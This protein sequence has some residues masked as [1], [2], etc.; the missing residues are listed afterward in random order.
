[1]LFALLLVPAAARANESATYKTTIAA[2]PD[3]PVV[4]EKCD[5]RKFGYRVAIDGLTY[6]NVSSLQATAVRFSFTNLSAFDDRSAARLYDDLGAISKGAT[7]DRLHRWNTLSDMP[8][9]D[10]DHVEC[11][12]ER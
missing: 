10:P 5:S 9:T 3:V 11:A 4:I 8:L 2:Q 12:V 6:H 7:I 1:M